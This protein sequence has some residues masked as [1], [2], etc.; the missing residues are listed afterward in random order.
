MK[1][2][3]TV[4]TILAAG[5]I[6]LRGQEVLIDGSSHITGFGGPIF[7]FSSIDGDVVV[8]TGGGG[9]A[10]FDNFFL[11]GY[12]LGDTD[13]DNKFW[14]GNTYDVEYSHGGLWLG[15]TADRQDMLHWTASLRMGWGEI[16]ARNLSENGERFDDA[17]FVLTPMAG[18]EVN[19]TH[20]FKMGA[21]VGFRWTAGAN[22]LFD[23]S[24]SDFSS[25]MG[26]LVLKFGWFR[27]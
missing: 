3:I 10:V 21:S 7:E 26:Q 11:G 14:D 19:I 13:L 17:V 27:E 16:E 12:G 1:K 25:A 18:G 15:Y 24:N 22:K 4:L 2:I 9:A 23:Y 8:S 5:W 20:W 6:Q